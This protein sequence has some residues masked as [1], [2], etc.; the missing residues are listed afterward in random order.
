MGRMPSSKFLEFASVNS[1]VW[2]NLVG[3]TLCDD[4]LG[5]GT[6]SE[7]GKN[8]EY[9]ETKFSKTP[10]TPQTPEVTKKRYRIPEDFSGDS[11]RIYV[12]KPESHTLLSSFLRNRKEKESPESENKRRSKQIKDFCAERGIET[13]VHFTRFENLESILN[14]GLLSRKELEKW[15]SE[16]QFVFNDSQR[17]DQCLESICLSISFPNYKMFYHYRQ[18]NSAKWAVILLKPNILWELD[19]AFC[20]DNAAG[21]LVREIPLSERKNVHYL[22]SMFKDHLKNIRCSLE[23]PDSYTTS[24]QAEVLVFDPIPAEYITEI[25]FETIETFNSWITFHGGNQANEHL[26]KF[27]TEFFQPRI[28][29]SKWQNNN[30]GGISDFLDEILFGGDFFN[31]DKGKNTDDEI[32]F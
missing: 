31:D 22:Y 3:E 27:E 32:P 18:K 30:I 14:N 13:L 25:H 10:Q 21:S 9:L 26:F 16:N 20:N 24:P 12:E 6:I 1:K 8:H 15:G 11:F 5:C 2:D 4:E 29:Y 23:I 19:C 28:D 17:I 7:M